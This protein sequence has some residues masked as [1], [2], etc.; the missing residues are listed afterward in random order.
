[1]QTKPKLAQQSADALKEKTKN[2]DAPA[3]MLEVKMDDL[4]LAALIDHRADSARSDWN[5]APYNL[6]EVRES[7]QKLYSTEYVNDWQVDERYE[8]VV[9]DNRMFTSVRTIIPFVT[10]Q[11][12]EPEVTASDDN[13]LS[14]Q[15]ARDLEKIL[16]LHSKQQQAKAKIK[17]SVQDNLRGQRIGY[18]K[19]RYDA[20]R[21]TITLEHVDPSS[22]IVDSKA[23]QHEEPRFLQH[24]QKRTIGDL[25]RQFPNKKDVLLQL[26]ELSEKAEDYQ[27]RLDEEQEITENWLFVNE[28]G[29]DTLVVS[30][31]VKNE[32]LAK[33]KDPNF[34][35]GGQ[36]I[37][38]APMI[39]FI[40]FNTLNDG[41]SL[42]DQTSYMEQSHWL[43]E[44]YDK[45]SMAIASN[46]KFGGI[47]VPV[48][49]KKAL[50]QSDAAKIQ[51]SPLQRILLDT[52]DVRSSFTTWQAGT[53]Q[54]FVVEDKYDSR[55]SID[56]IWGT[57]NIMRG[58]QSKN[59]TLGQDV[60]IRDQAEGRQSEI[61]DAIDTA[62]ARYYK[63]LT[64]M[65]YR[66]FDEDHYYKYVGSDGKFV[67]LV[68]NQ[69]KLAK[70]LGIDVNVKTGSS[71]PVDRAQ[72]R[73]VAL[74]LAQL[75]RISTLRLYKE[76]GLENA[77]EAYKQWVL[78]SRDPST[79]LKDADSN[80]QDRAAQEDLAVV[81]G[82]E[83]PDERD[84]VTDEY[85]SYLNDYLLTDKLILLENE[86]PDA[87]S[88]V[89]DFISA[90]NTKAK[91]KLSKLENQARNQPQTPPTPPEGPPTIPPR[92][93]PAQLASLSGAA[94]LVA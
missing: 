49:S 53:L 48:F 75:N 4:Q 36:N 7:N 78:E 84:D 16:V 51:F 42:I 28:D 38:D 76:L 39:P 34:I 90:I 73:A 60:L 80:Q 57:P 33:F 22:V 47:G 67:R 40:F 35:W 88:R 68:I 83:I 37:L 46:A 50:P 26:F 24:T 87:A 89:R 18:L 44:N 15:F 29:E 94:P 6:T 74:R 63:I 55:N 45:R 19:L 85:L 20:K 5:K 61:I 11:I 58:E 12:T 86:D 17:I 13:P 31:K 66:Y 71:L 9:A 14:L 41:S 25:L 69:K 8:D 27:I 77:E 52:T 91:I 43:Q 54:S 32:I 2:E 72:K 70:Y 56:N 1:M 10:S 3:S 23:R 79:M 30:W 64:Q 21:N 82:G 81:I 59:N 62:M 65:I 93:D 92:P